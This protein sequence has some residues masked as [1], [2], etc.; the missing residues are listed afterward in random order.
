[1]TQARK[2]AIRP[3]YSGLIATHVP[4]QL[5]VL[6]AVGDL[7]DDRPGQAAGVLRG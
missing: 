1:M 4:A 3:R 7:H 6:L 2:S 5:Q